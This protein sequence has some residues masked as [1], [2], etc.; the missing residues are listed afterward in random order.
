MANKRRTGRYRFLLIFRPHEWWG[1]LQLL[2]GATS[3]GIGLY[4]AVWF[5]VRPLYYRDLTYA[6]QGSEWLVFL[7]FFGLGGLLWVNGRIEL[8]DAL[9]SYRA[10]PVLEAESLLSKRS[11][12]A[13]PFP[14]QRVLQGLVLGMLAG[15]VIGLLAF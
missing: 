12:Q 15:V 2:V 7:L 9:P 13:P 4:W 5:A 1:L 3:I 14:M 10:R 6:I 11:K 8:R